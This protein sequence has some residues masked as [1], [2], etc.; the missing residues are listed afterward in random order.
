V[1]AAY[2]HLAEVGLLEIR[3]G[4]GVRVA[5][6]GAD[7]SQRNGKDKDDEKSLDGLVFEFLA[8]VADRGY[9]REDL[10]STF[11]NIARRR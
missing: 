11:N 6:R 7:G 5:G 3:Q 4:S 8:K 1:T 9:S 10:I 2:N